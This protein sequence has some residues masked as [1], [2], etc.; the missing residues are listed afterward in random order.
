MKDLDKFKNE[1]NLSGQ[2]VYVGHRYVPKLVGEW[3]NTNLYEPLSIVQYQGNSFT[4]RQYVPVGIEITNEEFWVATGNYNAQVEQYRQDVKTFNDNLASLIEKTEGDL[5]D[6]Q[7]TITEINTKIDNTKFSVSVKEFGA[8]GDGVTNDQDAINAAIKYAY[9]NGIENVV[10][11]YTGSPY[12]IK[13]YEEGQVDYWENCTGVILKSGITLHIHPKAEIKIIPNARRATTMFNIYN[14]ENVKIIGGRITGDKHSHLGTEGEWGYGIAISGSDNVIIEDVYIRQMW[15]DGI[16]LQR[17]R[18]TYP[19]EIFG[20]VTES[21][22]NKDV[23]VD[24]VICDDNRRQGMSV[25][26]VIRMTIKESVFKN[27]GGT[28]PQAG[29]DIEPWSRFDA[30][31]ITIVN[32]QCYGNTG[33]GIYAYQA[34]LGNLLIDNYLAYDNYMEDFKVI[35]CEAKSIKLIN[36]S[37]DVIGF[38][39]NDDL[40]IVTVRNNDFKSLHAHDVD[41]IEVE[42]NRIFSPA[43]KIVKGGDEFVTQN[44]LNFRNI[45]TDKKLTAKI[46]GNYVKNSYGGYYSTALDIRNVDAT[47]EGNHFIGYRYGIYSYSGNYT[48]K[49]NMFINLWTGYYN[50]NGSQGKNLINDNIFE[51][52]DRSGSQTPY[53]IMDKTNHNHVVEWNIVFTYPRNVEHYDPNVTY[54][55]K[56]VYPGDSN[57]VIDNTPPV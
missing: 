40:G 49:N 14:I 23:I 21:K 11:P 2:N 17:Y 43:Q 50:A 16:N 5:S 56:T 4:S 39:K 9:E 18:N 45:D 13:G 54:T 28:A 20:E 53:V 15:G 52:S 33:A 46:K 34:K 24:N 8:K 22:P 32:T 35:R 44:V 57:K 12:M 37:L 29:I 38:S 3:D 27:T 10:I 55:A 1:M 30:R 31:E 19:T 7:N 42:D 51:G 47:I 6:M 36:S 48:I 41:Y 26:A 25:E